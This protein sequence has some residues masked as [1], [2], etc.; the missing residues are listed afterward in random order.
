MLADDEIRL[1]RSPR[2]WWG[3]RLA[4]RSLALALACLGASCATTRSAMQSAERVAQG[5]SV[6][7]AGLS[8]AFESDRRTIGSD[9]VQLRERF[10]KA[11]A[12]LRANVE[13]RWGSRDAKVASR[14]VYVKYTEG[15]KTRVVTD[16]DKGVVTIET[17]DTVE[18]LKGAIVAALLTPNDP[19][20]L[21][22][23]SD[24]EVT[25]EPAHEPYLYGLVHDQ[26]GRSIRTRRQAEEYAAYLV[27]RKLQVRAVSGGEAN[28]MAHF[29]EL[30][31]VRNFE[32]KNAAH[33]RPLVERYAT[34]YGVSPTLV[35]AIIRTESNFNPFA[36][37]AAPAYGLMQ[38]VPT[39]GGR[40]ALR[41]VSGRDEAPSPQ[42][43]LDPDHN[44]ELGSAYL[45]ELSNEEFR[46]VANPASRDYCVIAAYNTG[47]GNVM[48]TFSRNREEA[49]QDINAMPPSAL[50]D[51]LRTGLPF[52][53][54][55]TYVVRVTGYRR[56]YAGP[57]VQAVA[58]TPPAG[59]AQP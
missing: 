11:L 6:D 54:T 37:S 2:R 43:L 50:F 29:V 23:F 13:Q 3:D 9:L 24:Q 5:G 26:H 16:F 31:M 57:A 49:L 35:L 4:L 38:L 1:S 47:A 59:A 55:R 12:R 30:H 48:R 14:T 25:L 20:A 51:R 32:A 41:R 34:R 46:S 22:L 42:Y 53:E 52:E 33:Y 15:Y 17:L 21:D 58:A 10:A 36:V 27:A 8:H 19:A 56:A 18:S 44:I 39:S 28:A 7:R 45:G 40:E